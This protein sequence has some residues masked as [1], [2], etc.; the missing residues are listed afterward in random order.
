MI[1]IGHLI[2][3]IV[4]MAFGF[5]CSIICFCASVKELITLIKLEKN[6]K[7]MLDKYQKITY[8]NSIR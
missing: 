4:I 2:T 8:N 3:I 1:F 6:K 5:I 7:E